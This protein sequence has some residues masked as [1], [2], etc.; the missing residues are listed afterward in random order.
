MKISKQE[1]REIIKE[2][3]YVGGTKAQGNAKDNHD[4]HQ[5]IANKFLQK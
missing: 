3:I 5:R 2:E 4:V 1:L